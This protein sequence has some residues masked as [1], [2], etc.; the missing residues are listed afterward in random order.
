MNAPAQT[1][2]RGIDADRAEAE[3]LIK[4]LRTYSRDAMTAAIC[5]TSMQLGFAAELLRAYATGLALATPDP[6]TDA[7]LIQ[8]MQPETAQP[9]REDTVLIWTAGEPE[10]PWL[11][12]YDGARWWYVDALPASN[13]TGWAYR[14]GEQK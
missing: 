14:P 11:G 5:E 2:R 4:L 9:D 8:R 7:F 10:T 6:E 1:P 12:Y 13:V 3:R